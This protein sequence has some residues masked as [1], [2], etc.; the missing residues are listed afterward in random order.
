MFGEQWIG[1]FGPVRWPPRSPDLT[2]MDF[3]LWGYVK[4]EVYATDVSTV[5]ELR[6]RIIVA[7]EKLKTLTANSDIIPR[8]KNNIRRRYNL[9][10]NANGGHFEHLKI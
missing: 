5:E 6:N 9:C 4:G 10:I 1:R 8:L 3:F 2:P 7:F